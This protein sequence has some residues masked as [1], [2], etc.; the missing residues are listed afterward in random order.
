MVKV[1][2]PALITDEPVM[3]GADLLRDGPVRPLPEG[4]ARGSL[5][6]A[7]KAAERLAEAQVQKAQD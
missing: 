6:R 7:E 1:L 2:R 4:A 3:A 5:R